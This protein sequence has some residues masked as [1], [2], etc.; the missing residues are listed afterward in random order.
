M[1]IA[2]GLFFLLGAVGK[3]A[4]PHDAVRFAR[5]V[6]PGNSLTL[7][8]A[9]ASVAFLVAVEFV[10]AVALIS[11]V[12]RRLFAGFALT[13]VVVFGSIVAYAW[14]G[15]TLDSCGCL[16]LAG[17][18]VQL[19]STPQSAF[20][21]NLGLAAALAWILWH[22]KP[23]ICTMRGP[24]VK[25][26]TPTGFTLIETLVVI[27]VIAI[28]IAITLPALSGSRIAARTARSQ[29]VSGQL[30]AALTMYGTDNDELFPF[31]ATRGD[32]FGPKWLFGHDM[33]T[34]YLG[35]QSHYYASLLVPNYIDS[36]QALEQDWI[37]DKLRERGYPAQVVRADHYLT[38]SAFT[39]TSYWYGEETPHEPQHFRPAR[40]AEL[41]FPSQK[42]LLFDQYAGL[43]DRLRS[44]RART[45]SPRIHQEMVI[46]QG[47]GAA[48]IR[49]W[50]D[51][52]PYIID[53]SEHGGYEWPILTSIDGFA[54]IDF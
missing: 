7:P 10:I 30:L 48:V 31:F 16:G 36:R 15:G 27:A 11:G 47:D 45:H 26:D 24:P 1:S 20:F 18:I 51:S 44:E 37:R 41:R 4:D 54:G 5:I 3:L 14:A 42:G 6:M 39:S 43:F 34:S 32:P 53:R 25:P 2:L 19:G 13:L 35:G 22:S 23:R 12:R 21:R 17:R 50:S 9:K 49:R 8:L 46:G 38:Y 40:W 52:L 29:A 28:V 33:P